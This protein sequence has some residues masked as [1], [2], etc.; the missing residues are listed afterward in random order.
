MRVLAWLLCTVPVKGPWVGGPPQPG[1]MGG[2]RASLG[3]T[4]LV[5][6]NSG[7][8]TRPA[9][10]FIATRE[11]NAQARLPSR[12]QLAYT[13]GCHAWD[14]GPTG[15]VGGNP[16]YSECWRKTCFI[17]CPHPLLTWS[18]RERFKSVC[19]VPEPSD[20][21]PAPLVPETG[22]LAVDSGALGVSHL[23]SCEIS[24]FFP[25][26]GGGFLVL[27]LRGRFLLKFS[28]CSEQPQEV[29][30]L[31]SQHCSSAFFLSIPLPCQKKV[32][33][34][35]LPKKMQEQVSILNVQ[36]R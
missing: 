8:G 14:P 30:D 26:S 20:C 6:G 21:C 35:S 3:P 15:S 9:P 4:L 29:F 24:W 5:C 11:L 31:I 17:V 16:V 27:L 32:F 22:L 19:R 33:L 7:E 28:F 25:S 34:I 23:G 2:A 13:R 18:T 10:A 12:L 1:V 36:E